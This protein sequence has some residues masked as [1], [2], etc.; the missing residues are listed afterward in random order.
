MYTQ[1]GFA[2]NEHSRANAV[3]IHLTTYPGERYLVVRIGK[4]FLN[5]PQTTQHLASMALSQPPPE[6][7]ISLKYQKVASTSS[8]ALSTST[9]VTV[10]G[11]EGLRLTPLHVD[12]EPFTIHVSLPRRK[13]GDTLLLGVHDE[14]QV[15]SV[16]KLPWY[17]SAKLKR[18]RLQH[19]VEEQWAKDRTLMHTN[20][21]A[22]LFTVLT[23]DPHPTPSIGV[24]ALDDTRSPFLNHEAP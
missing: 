7:S 23:I 12:M 5:F 22:K 10:C 11:A 2:T 3:L 21:H 15:I 8:M 24:H 13:L 16:D 4:S 20:S 14:H 9:W 6:Q 1:G 18:K 19:K 17:P